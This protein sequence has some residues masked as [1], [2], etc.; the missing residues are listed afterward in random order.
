[1]LN[2][3]SDDRS[4][5][6]EALADICRTMG[7]PPRCLAPDLL[8]ACQLRQFVTAYL[9]FR[10]LAM[11]T[12]RNTPEDDMPIL[13]TRWLDPSDNGSSF[14]SIKLVLGGR[15]AFTAAGLK[16]QLWDLGLIS[17]NGS[18]Y[19]PIASTMVDMRSQ[20]VDDDTIMYMHSSR[21][22]SDRVLFTLTCLARDGR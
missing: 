19:E 10:R 9:R 4:I 20:G 21:Y 13:T 11:E 6:S 5:W 15:Y 7:I 16:I 1:M 12:A 8:E 18:S 2:T 22:F 14:Q 3:A 17:G